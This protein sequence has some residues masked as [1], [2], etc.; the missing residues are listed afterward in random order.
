MV[1]DRI[2]SN[3]ILVIVTRTVFLILVLCFSVAAS[4][5]SSAAT[6]LGLAARGGTPFI[7]M[8]ELIT[9]IATIFS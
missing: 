8:T 1:G 7:G 6:K 5:Q 3:V 2:G 9:E 4:A